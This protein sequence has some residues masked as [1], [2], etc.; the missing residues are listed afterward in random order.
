MR[1]PVPLKRRDL[2]ILLTLAGRALAADVQLQAPN[3]VVIGPQLVTSGQPGA[4]A[5]RG[6]GAQGFEAVIYLAPLTVPDAVVEEPEILRRQ[7]IEFI[8]IPVRFGQ[9]TGADFAAFT[10]A[11]DRLRGRKLLV[12]C[13]V[14]LRASSMT[15]L[16]R[17][18]AGHEKPDTAYEAVARVW[19]PEGP[20]KRLLV[21]QLRKARIAFE[22]Y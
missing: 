21:A 4:A 8:H 13:Q 20:W 18:I 19:S 15:F 6:L 22:P 14:N 17:V 7:N 12:H 2:V 11:M 10:Q 3:V 9:P 16:Y 1:L 5:L